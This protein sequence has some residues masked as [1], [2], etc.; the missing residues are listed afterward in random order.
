MAGRLP[1]PIR[2]RTVYGP[3]LPDWL[4]RMTDARAELAAEPRA[5]RDD[6]VARQFIDVPRLDAALRDWPEPTTAPS[7]ELMSTYR[8]A[9]LRALLAGRYVRW[10]AGWRPPS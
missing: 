4:D 1:D 8:Q 5:T 10:F 3:Q 6:P 7:K 9:L 2:L